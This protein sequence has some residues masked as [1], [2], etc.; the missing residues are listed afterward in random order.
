MQQQ[1]TAIPLCTV[2]IITAWT[3]TYVIFNRIY[4]GNMSV[5]LWIDLSQS[6][7]EEKY[8]KIT[9]DGIEL[10]LV[11]PHLYLYILGVFLV[12]KFR[13]RFVSLSDFAELI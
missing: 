13:I 10:C 4:G 5:E 3:L 1:I 12:A 11:T 6:Q 2:N 7:A 8:S 9:V